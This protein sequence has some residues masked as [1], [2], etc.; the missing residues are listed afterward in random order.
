MQ[1]KKK[2]NKAIP[3]RIDILP[4]IHHSFFCSLLNDDENVG[5]CFNKNKYW[6]CFIFFLVVENDLNFKS[7][8]WWMDLVEM[9]SFLR[10]IYTSYTNMKV[11]LLIFRVFFLLFRIYKRFIIS[12]LFNRIETLFLCKLKVLSYLKSLIR[13]SDNKSKTH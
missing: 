8:A 10:I 2:L 7:L 4:F 11:M 3:K 6:S 1:K 13:W 9:V 12:C 5:Y